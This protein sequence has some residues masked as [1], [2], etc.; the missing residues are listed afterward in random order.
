[1]KYITPLLFLA[2]VFSY[3]RTIGYYQKLLTCCDPLDISR[4]YEI[5]KNMTFCYELPFN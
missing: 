4:E 2:S 5:R 3:R 1:M